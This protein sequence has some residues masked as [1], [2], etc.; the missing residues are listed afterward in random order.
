MIYEHEDDEHED[1]STI[2]SNFLIFFYP[3][4]NK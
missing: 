1:A 2:K 3:F 4:L